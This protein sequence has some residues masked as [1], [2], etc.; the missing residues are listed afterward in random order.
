M[1][2]GAVDRNDKLA[3]FSSRGPLVTSNV[4][5][6][7]L[8][9][10]GV[11]IVAARAA[12]TNLQDPI[13][14]YYEGVSGTSMASPH[15]AG[16]A[17]LLAQRHPDWTGEQLKAAL[18]GAADPL[19]GVDAYAVGAGRLNAA[20]ALGGPTSNQPVV[21][22]GTF[23]Y[24]QSG[25]SE[26]KLSWTGAAT[27]ATTA[28][29]L[30]VSVVN[31]D[32]QP[33]PR[34]AASLSTSRV[35]LKRGVTAGATLRINRAAL[36]ARP[37]FYL[38]TVT[39]RTAGR[40]LVSTT[41]VSFY[42][43][44]PSYD[45][46]IHTKPLPGLKEGAESWINILVTNLTDP[47]IYY[48]GLGGAPGDT[49]TTRVPAGRYAIL[50]SSVAYYVDSDVLETTLAGETD[51]NVTGNR[52]VTLDPAR[53]KPVTA[54]V[55]GV[56]TKPTRVDFTNLQTAPNGLSWWN[57]ISGYGAATTVRTSPLPKPGVGSRRT[58]AAVNLDSPAGTAKPYRYNLIHEYPNGVPADPAYR[59]TTAEQTKLARIDERF[60]QMDSEGMVTQLVRTGLTP[61]GLGLTQ[62]HEG[63]L[64]PYRTD[65][66]SPGILWA[67]R[68][69]RLRRTL[70][71]GGAAQLP[72][73]EP[74]IQDLGA[75]AAAL[76][77][78]RRPGRCR[79]ELR[80]RTVA[81]PGQPAHR[82][83]VVGG[84][85]PAGRLP[86][87]QLDR[88]EPQAVAVPERQAGGG[89]GP[90]ARRLHCPATGGELPADPR[91]RHE[92]DPADLH[93]GQ[94]L[95]DVPIHRAGRDRKCAVAVAAARG[96]L[97]ASDGHQQPRHRGNGRAG[98]SAG[99]RR[100]G[101]EGD[102]VPGLD[103]DGRRRHLEDGPGHP[104]R[105]QLPGRAAEGRRRAARLA[106]GEGRRE[107]R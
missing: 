76:R 14:T 47:V 82:P 68:R 92:P 80:D 60:H 10:P 88:G 58:W 18:V 4:A 96:R 107:R 1:T 66:L 75:A 34:G 9:A 72:A 40:K 70:G 55:D 13:D 77:L 101:T 98:R 57:Q 94:H 59:V 26:A 12:G 43:E 69:G 25:T 46:T 42:V 38:A 30:D 28:L 67:G 74:A 86:A 36:A 39:A 99:P 50:G 106:A 8:V 11:D 91:R 22:L 102:L 61:N 17:A 95:V 29:D 44:Q 49:F 97:R 7:E 56:A 15:V 79:L 6:P 81:D 71:P 53:T 78:V 5:K 100:Q 104:Q 16:A 41:P 45:L 37:G 105:G 27:S 73:G 19:T 24:P 48:G 33:V 103:V 83:G 63:N 84:P 21:N 23:A 93:P 89:A 51:L 54:T 31:H 3:D 35:T 90:P 2:V 20:R 85:A 64:P 87:G 52:S 62:T 32:G 65:Y